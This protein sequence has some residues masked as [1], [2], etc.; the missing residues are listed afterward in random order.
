[1]AAPPTTVTPALAE[2][3]I[4]QSNDPSQPQLQ[5]Q[6]TQYLREWTSTSP[7]LVLM[8]LLQQSAHERVQFYALTTLGRSHALVEPDR[9][10]LRQFLLHQFDPQAPFLRNKVAWVLARFV[11]QDVPG[12]WP[13]LEQDLGHLVQRQPT[14]FL[15]TI[16][17]V[18]EDVNEVDYRDDGNDTSGSS[19]SFSSR[20][21]IRRV[22]DFLKGYISVTGEATGRHVQT[23]TTDL[24]LLERIFEMVVRLLEQSL[25]EDSSTVVLCLLTL[26]SVF[27]WTDI[28]SL[29]AASN[30]V[31]SR[32]LEI[33]LHIVASTFSPQVHVACLQA[34]Q[35]WS[36][37]S[38]AS[39]ITDDKAYWFGY[40]FPVFASLLEHVHK[41]NVIPYEGESEAEIEVVIEIAKLVCAVGIEVLPVWKDV[42]RQ[43]S[44]VV[45]NE[46][47]DLFYRVFKYDD[48]DVSAAVLPFID[49]LTISIESGKDADLEGHIPRILTIVYEQMQY[50]NDFGY[51]YDDD[52][53][54]EEVAYREELCRIYVKLIRI[55]QAT[56]LQFVCE[57]AQHEG[58]NGSLASVPTPRIE[59]LLRFIYHFCEGVR[60]APGLKTLTEGPN[61]NEAF[62]SL[63]VALHRS[64]ITDHSHHEVLCLYYETAVR[65]YVIFNPAFNAAEPREL[66]AKVLSAMSGNRG[67]LHDHP[68]VRS[69][70]C[71]LLFKLIKTMIGQ[72]HRE[73]ETTVVGINSLLAT[74]S[75]GLRSEDRL[76]LFET[77][78]ILIGKGSID[79]DKRALFLSQLLLP[80]IDSMKKLTQEKNGHSYSTEDAL[81]DSLSA[82]ARLATGFNVRCSDAIK[83][84]FFSTLDPIQLVLSSFADKM[85]V[86]SKIMIVLQRLILCIG[87]RILP[88]VHLFIP[89]LI[90]YADDDDIAFVC[91]FLI[92]LCAKFKASAGPVID[93][94]ILPFTT[95]CHEL[96]NLK[97]AG[98]HVSNGKKFETFMI[99]K[100]MCN[101]FQHMA[102]YK[103]SPVLVSQANIAQLPAV[104]QTMCEG[105][106]LLDEGTI[107]RSCF[108]FF[109]DVLKEW[110]Q[111]GSQTEPL[112]R[113]LVSFCS[114]VLVPTVFATCFFALEFDGNDAQHSRSLGDFC[115]IV[116]A[117]QSLG[118]EAD[119]RT[120]GTS[121]ASQCAQSNGLKP[122]AAEICAVFQAS[123]DATRQAVDGLIRKLK[124]GDAHADALC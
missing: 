85:V 104:F 27:T 101:L 2:Q 75:Q 79:Q 36:A 89:T 29:Q 20:E 106:C 82:L 94:F 112:R 109:R 26:R 16:E 15:K 25:T 44:S 90:Q 61:R 83:D 98:S 3:W 87:D 28:V 6:A 48:I 124:R 67:I 42:D 122:S 71:Y 23:V 52:D 92:Q 4:L 37:S 59:A 96:I 116:C 73:A 111:L 118:S 88:K 107:Q 38:N 63:L 21:S 69:R 105:S 14:L 34:W 17:T 49:K 51:D 8:Q 115:H 54:A 47:I 68:R 77:M 58:R 119:V 74:A 12:R 86:R 76:Y 121:V 39:F 91:Q 50:P 5:W 45:F 46:V 99:K 64:D 70:C 72:L 11:W 65:Y 33:L 30:R 19:T 95:K 120:L 60:P 18:L 102:M 7:L 66:L 24:C 41:A 110:V 13:T 10:S 108:K 81:A 100:Q 1:M 43:Q 22:K 56:C 53:D 103:L 35:E 9:V 93:P 117:L 113:E 57:A 31:S 84:V 55:D 78:G 32:A 97:V 62:M 40:K 114:S 123:A 80:H